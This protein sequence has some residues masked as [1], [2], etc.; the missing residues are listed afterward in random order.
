[1]RLESLTF[2]RF[3]AAYIV[4]VFHFGSKTGL[5]NLSKPFLTSGSEMVTFF[6]VLSGFVLWISQSTRPFLARKYFFARVG[7]IYP[8]HILALI[9]VVWINYGINS[10]NNLTGLL[11]SVPLIQS[12]FPTY[13]TAFNFPTWSLAV[14]MFFYVTFPLLLFLIKKSKV[15]SKRLFILAIIFWLFTQ[16]VLINLFNS[17]NSLVIKQ[18][19]NYFPPSHLCS[20]VLGISV[21]LF[22]TENVKRIEFRHP[23]FVLA[24]FV[25]V[26]LVLQYPLK[27]IFGYKIPLGS[28][29]LA[30][31][32]AFPIITL[33][34][35]KHKFNDF[36][37]NKIFKLLGE[38][39][40][41]VYVF[42]MPLYMVIKKFS[43][44]FFNTDQGFYIYSVC[45]IVISIIIYYTFE[46]PLNK[47]IRRLA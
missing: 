11:L 36:L 28:S 7:R 16:L 10:K 8:I 30:P 18:L 43:P 41:G 5:A 31:V 2:L 12:W 40:Y 37:G 25:L 47:N 27:N 42:H 22:Y 17:E 23:W 24:A 19:V 34:F 13:S 26:Y 14:E 38:A 15:S 9:I 33:A 45:L 46:K 20:F 35:S 6:F 4:V 1:L 44:H 29:F 3:I 32:F 21:G 39:S